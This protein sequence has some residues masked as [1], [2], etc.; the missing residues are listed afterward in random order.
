ML[1]L[2]LL[3][4]DGFCSK[5]TEEL[6]ELVEEMLRE[7]PQ[8]TDTCAVKLFYAARNVFIMYCDVVPHFHS[9]LLDSIP[10][11]SGKSFIA[12]ND[13]FT[14]IKELL[15]EVKT[16]K[17]LVYSVGSK[18]T[19]LVVDNF[20]NYSS[21]STQQRHVPRSPA[22][23]PGRKARAAASPGASESHSHLHRPG[24]PTA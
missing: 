11:Q 24:R 16:Y 20:Y 14:T 12:V 17:K 1:Y 2:K 18:I 6:L 13:S 9:R 23:I 5:S 15:K 8:N 4:V 19:V 3:T 10:Q 7:I 22:D 21:H